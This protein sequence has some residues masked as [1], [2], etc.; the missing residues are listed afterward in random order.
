[1]V[2]PDTAESNEAKKVISETFKTYISIATT[3]IVLTLYVHQTFATNHRVDEIAN[4][5][6]KQE[7]ISCLTALE[8]GVKK[9]AIK[10]ICQLNLR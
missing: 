3:A 10:D 9:E 7:R 2:K 1:M 5:L 6:S 8:V 4:K